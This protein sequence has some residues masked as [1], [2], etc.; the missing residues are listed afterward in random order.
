MEFYGWGFTEF[1]KVDRDIRK[2][3]KKALKTIGIYIDR[4]SNYVNQSLA[5]LIINE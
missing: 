3:F 1:N 4:P 5:D 2:A